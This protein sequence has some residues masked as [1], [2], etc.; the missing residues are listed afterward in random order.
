MNGSVTLRVNGL[1][2]GGSGSFAIW[3]SRWF[4]QKQ[5]PHAT[6]RTAAETMIRLRSS[7]RCSTSVI[8]S[9]KL[10]AL[11]RGTGTSAAVVGYDLALDGLRGLLAALD[12]LRLRRRL[13]IVVVVVARD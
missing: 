11:S 13:I 7:S 9:S 5:S 8:R 3:S 10:A 6:T 2:P 12:L 1:M 4:C